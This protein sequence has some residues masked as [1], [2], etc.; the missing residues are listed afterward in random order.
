MNNPYWKERLA[1]ELVKYAHLPHKE[2]NIKY[3]ELL[4]KHHIDETIGFNIKKWK[5]DN[6]P[7]ETIKFKD[8]PIDEERLLEDL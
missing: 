7:K 4:K 5:K 3:K 6:L 1:D 2:F 8:L